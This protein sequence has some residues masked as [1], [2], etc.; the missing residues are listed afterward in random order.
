MI[1]ASF[2]RS[3]N[4]ISFL[5]K[6][7]IR[8][9]PEF[10]VMILVNLSLIR[11][12]GFKYQIFS[13]E[14]LKWFSL[15]LTGICTTPSFLESYS[16]GSFNGAL[17]TIMVEVQLYIVTI[18]LYP[19]AKKLKLW[20]WLVVVFMFFM[21]E[22]CRIQFP[23]NRLVLILDRTFITHATPFLMGMTIYIFREQCFETINKISVQLT[24]IYVLFCAVC[25]NFAIRKTVALFIVPI[26]IIGLAYKIGSHRFSFDISYSIYLYHMVV[27]NIWIYMGVP[28][29]IKEFIVL[30]VCIA[31]ISMLSGYLFSKVS[32]ILKRS[33]LC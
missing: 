13:T 19:I 16:V 33:R 7:V 21:A 18:F 30:S 27:M 4:P 10:W 29:G 1:A 25:P 8:L 9:Y 32:H 14:F 23:N 12:V 6:R 22:T 5:K 24:I 2:E 3:S 17:W 15:E 31:G 26:C 20:K 28:A 11:L